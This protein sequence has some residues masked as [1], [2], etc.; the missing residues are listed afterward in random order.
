MGG[1]RNSGHPTLM[2]FP[3]DLGRVLSDTKNIEPLL[4]Q[5]ADHEISTTMPLG[6]AVMAILRFAGE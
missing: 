3:G 4:R 5:I 1:G 6:N 2:G